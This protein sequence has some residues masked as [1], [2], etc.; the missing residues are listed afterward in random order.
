MIPI[1]SCSLPCCVEDSGND[2]L[3]EAE[4]PSDAKQNE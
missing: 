2:K 1:D 3:I 4:A